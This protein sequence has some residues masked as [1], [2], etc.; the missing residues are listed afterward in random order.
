MAFQRFKRIERN[1]ISCNETES[2]IKFILL[3][4]RRVL[5]RVD[6]CFLLSAA[7]LWER[8]I[9]NCCQLIKLANALSMLHNIWIY[10]KNASE[11]WRNL[12]RFEGLAFS[13]SARPLIYSLNF[14]NRDTLIFGLVLHSFLRNICSTLSSSRGP[15][16]RRSARIVA[17]GAP[18]WFDL[19]WRRGRREEG[20]TSGEQ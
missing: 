9:G 10:T 2:V 1:R 7:L 5:C 3:C 14:A 12:W 4:L 6:A 17:A 13:E 20:A 16:T 8:S 19:L 11:I 15:E 18:D